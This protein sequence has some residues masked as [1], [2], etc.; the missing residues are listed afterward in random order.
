MQT[1][2]VVSPRPTHR[3]RTLVI[4]VLLGIAAAVGL[5]VSLGI[6]A[7]D[8]RANLRD[9][10]TEV[11]ALEDQVRAGDAEAADAT[12]ASLQE[13]AAAAHAATDGALWW[14]AARVPGVGPS[15]QGVAT[16]AAVVDS[17][18]QDALPRL[19]RAR[20]AVS[21]SALTPVDGRIDLQPI[22]DVA[23]E[24]V[25]ADDAVQGAR[26]RLA[27]L[28]PERMVGVVAG[29]VEDLAAQ[30]DEVAMTTAT[31]S[32]AV[33][34]LPPMLGADGPRTYAVLVQGN[35][36]IRSLG[37]MPGV[38]VLLR[39]DDGAVTFAG[40][41][42]AGGFTFVPTVLPLTDDE[43]NL[44]TEIL[45][46]YMSDVTM[47][48]DFP[49]SAELARAMLAQGKG[50]EVDGV[51][52]VDPVALQ[53]VLAVTGPVTTA[54]GVALT[55]DG[56]ADYLLRQVYF[57]VPEEPAQNAIF[58]DAARAVFEAVA[59]G[60]DEP[61]AL[62]DALA[63]SAGEGR[64]LAWSADEDEQALLAGTVLGGVLSGADGD[65]PV[66]G[67]YLNSGSAA[68]IDSYLDYSVV[69]DHVACTGDGASVV[70]VSVTLSSSVPEDVA[71]LP[72][73]VAGYGPYV[74]PG[75]IL[76]NVA[77][78]APRNG[79]IDSVETEGDIEGIS[80]FVHN[81]LEVGVQTIDLE[82]GESE[83][84]KLLVVADSEQSGPVRLRVTPGPHAAQV[85][86]NDFRCSG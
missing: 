80:P 21:P 19:A 58:A 65:S 69:A 16:V 85:T 5:I 50:I 55:G 56:A 33:Q 73:Y 71:S 79:W 82:P 78:Y 57:D 42:P 45:G 2:A 76:T 8:A 46:T 81:D 3:R 54:G 64:V 34:L 35:S 7:I 37:G 17:L 41:V 30:V 31:A 77:V 18:A 43:Q 36:E 32:R 72:D 86:V 38:I 26:E 11:A 10:A 29:P 24:V 60:K 27:A 74:E 67:V 47:T 15:V 28:E 83:M 52:A 23:P 13:H 63:R 62:V 22:V 6:D 53:N 4:G 20:A 39:A 59:A 44:Y 12:L 1:G 40:S 66:I 68:K 49:R 75:T 25:A 61:A 9:A 51:L 48:P 14:L 84:I 70:E